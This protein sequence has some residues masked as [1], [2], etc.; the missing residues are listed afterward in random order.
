MDLQRN[1]TEGLGLASSDSEQVQEADFC[2]QD[3]DPWDTKKCE[4]FLD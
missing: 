2:E 4:E 1:R 3:N